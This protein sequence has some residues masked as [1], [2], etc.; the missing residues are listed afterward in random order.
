MSLITFNRL[1]YLRPSG[2]IGDSGQLDLLFTLPVDIPILGI[3]STSH[4]EDQ[5]VSIVIFQP[6]AES[7][8]A[9][10]ERFPIQ[11]YSDRTFS[12]EIPEMTDF[13]EDQVHLV[14]KS[15]AL[16]REENAFDANEFLEATGYIHLSDPNLPGPEFD[17][18]QK[19]FLSAKPTSAEPGQAWEQ[20]YETYR[21]YR[22]DVCGLDLEP[23]V[24][25]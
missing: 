17:V 21:E 18:S 2:L 19:R 20:A 11:D 13:A 5:D 4:K 6:S 3:S 25:L 10:I 9:T 23:R 12:Q 15:S 24:V 7:Y 8:N 1:I 16:Q 14:A 22:M